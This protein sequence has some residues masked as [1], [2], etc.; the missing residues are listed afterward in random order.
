[1]QLTFEMN[2]FLKLFCLTLNGEIRQNYAYFFARLAQARI[3]WK[4]GG[5]IG[6]IL[7]QASKFSLKLEFPGKK[8]HLNFLFLLMK[9]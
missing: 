2:E 3:E 8:K 4:K 6:L 9:A 5:V 7:A 1:V